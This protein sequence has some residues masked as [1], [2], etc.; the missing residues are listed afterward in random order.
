MFALTYYKVNT[1]LRYF[2]IVVIVIQSGHYVAT[3]NYE[4][5]Y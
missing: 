2:G 5:L 3:L 4:L 1:Y